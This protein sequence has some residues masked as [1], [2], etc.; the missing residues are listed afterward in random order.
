MKKA[1]G[2]PKASRISTTGV[3]I[4]MVSRIAIMSFWVLVALFNGYFAW[5]I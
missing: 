2:C 5:L 4:M 3:Q 1:C